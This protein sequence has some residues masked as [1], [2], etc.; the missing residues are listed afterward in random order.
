MD[1]GA[2]EPS[3]T[4][5]GT[6][7]YQEGYRIG[8]TRII[9]RG[10]LNEELLDLFMLNSRMPRSVKGDFYAQVAACRTGE[11]RLRALL[12]R[13]GRACVAAAVEEIFDQ[14]ERLDRAAVAELPDGSWAAE[15]YM[16]S[17]G[18]GNGPVLVKLKVSI[19]GSDV[20]LDL[21]G[22]SP[23][24]KGCLN[25]G[26]PQ[27][28][29]AARLAFK[30]LINPELSATGGTFRC[31]HVIA[32]QGSIFAAR[33]PAACQYY[34]PH[35]GLMID[36]FITLMGN[37]LP[38][39]I[40]AA[41]CADPMNVF[42]DGINPETGET[43]VAGEAVAI[44]W[45]ASADADGENG[46]ANYGGGDLK[47]YPTEVLEN[48]YPIRIHSYGFVPDSGG[49]GRRRGGLALYRDFE[50]LTDASLSLWLERTVTGPWGVYGGRTGGTPTARLSRPGQPVQDLLKCS[51]VAMTA[52]SRLWVQ[53]GGGGGYGDPA[54]RE[55]DLVAADV[56]NGYLSPEA[57]E[58]DYGPT[59]M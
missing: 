35:A 55:P 36:L 42:F 11:L 9:R 43:W 2:K 38:E 5:D 8:P 58:R 27:T 15:G 37:V 49:A 48:K 53:T 20:T 54:D 6:E 26:L 39:R 24:T 13:F 18:Q 45:G 46:L 57:A 12:D 47:N 25:S 50:T 32:E 1:I 59:P 51:H 29:S 34:Y 16:D 56:I 33:E 19:E 41:Q 30:F 17:D 44:G 14:C 10:R 7:I 31:L 4:M 40:T 23:Q 52:G 21:T 28:L 3:Q 22:S